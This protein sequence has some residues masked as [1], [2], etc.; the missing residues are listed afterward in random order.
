MQT[1]LIH[2]ADA[3]R[4]FIDAQG[5]SDTR[6]RPLSDAALLALV[7]RL[8]FVQVDSI[9][10]VERAH[11]LILFSRSSSYR[12]AQLARLLERRGALFEN[13]TH[14]AAIIP[15]RFFPHWKRRFEREREALRERWR[16]WRRAGFEHNTGSILAQVQKTGPVMARHFAQSTTRAPGGW[17]DW[18][19]SKTALEFLWRTGEL[20]VARREGF[21]KVYDLTERVIPAEFRAASVTPDQL[22]DWACRGALDRLGYAT[23]GE[24][25]AFWGS[26]TAK[27]ASEWCATKLGGEVI[28]VR[29]APANGS[30]PRTAY[31]HADFP[32]RAAAAPR[33]PGRLRILS[34]FDPLVRDRNRTE[35]LFKF[36][37]RIEVFVPEAQREYGYYVFPLLERDRFVGRIDMKHRR[38]ESTLRVTSLWLEPRIKL[39]NSRRNKLEDELHR[40]RKFIGAPSLCFDNGALRTTR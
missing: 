28:E 5:L 2:N 29:V 25:A 9:N 8:G 26:I 10:T 20:A 11:H 34:P 12:R 16:K 35:R 7:E 1:P 22:I 32:E 3:R 36:R 18:H 21:Q 6:S 19:P 30:K 13:W 23:P 33:P 39:T 37:Y 15:T 31:A 27:E 17:W 14:D 40:L 24:L 4:Y 38:D